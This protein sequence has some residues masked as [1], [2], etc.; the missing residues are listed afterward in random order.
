MTSTSIP[1]AAGFAQLQA[2]D[3]DFARLLQSHGDDPLPA[4]ELCQGKEATLKV[5][6]R[7]LTSRHDRHAA[8][9]FGCRHLDLSKTIK[10]YG[11]GLGDPLRYLL[12]RGEKSGGSPLPLIEQVILNPRLF[13]A[14]LELDEGVRS[15]F[16]P[17]RRGRIKLL[18]P[19]QD[20][21]DYTNA[22]IC[23]PEL[24]LQ[25]ELYNALKLKLILVLD[26]E[27]GNEYFRQNRGRINAE[28]LKR[29][30]RLLR[31][32][33]PLTK[34]TL[35]EQA[36]V[37]VLGAGPSLE[38]HFSEIKEARRQGWYLV[39]VDSALMFLEQQRFPPDLVVSIDAL[40]GMQVGVR[41][42]K[43]YALY[44]HSTLIFEA[45]SQDRLWQPF[46][47]PRYY[48]CLEGHERELSWLKAGEGAVL[49]ASG[50]VFNVALELALLLKPRT[51]ALCGADFALSGDKTHAGMAKGDKAMVWTE[52]YNGT[53]PE[54]MLQIQLGFLNGTQHYD[55][56]NMTAVT[57]STAA[58]A[59]SQ[60]MADMKPAQSTAT[61]GWR[62]GVTVRCN[63][64]SMQPSMHN[65]LLY[66]QYVEESIRAHPQ[67]QFIN[68]AG[69]GAVIAGALWRPDLGLAV[70]H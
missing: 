70:P 35:P 67:V 54:Q 56:K 8:A 34:D 38:E 31:S 32:E 16:A 63:D 13:L 3:P 25:P 1:L 60:P 39:A 10:L 30:S 23:T 12:E 48:L 24:Y 46:P 20:R 37:L 7:Q 33:R 17:Q 64:G 29:N 15:L 5:D 2:F 62:S 59:N 41:F 19:E 58:T 14:L 57:A 9:A 27:F 66:R 55:G 49:R 45:C 11:F 51:V 53:T 47:G 69:H 36:K 61:P 50:S 42:F 52:T 22:V 21:F 28:Q 65:L 26:E 6:G 40:T 18:L 68:L 4:L 43:D 44:S